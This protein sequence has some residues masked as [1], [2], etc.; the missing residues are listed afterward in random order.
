MNLDK[1]SQ[2]L[3]STKTGKP[4]TWGFHPTAADTL[5]RWLDTRKALAAAGGWNNGRLLS[6]RYVRDLLPG[7]RRVGPRPARR[8]GGSAPG[9]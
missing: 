6:D 8:G 3:L 9:I 4:K 1:H 2:R 5:A 7:L